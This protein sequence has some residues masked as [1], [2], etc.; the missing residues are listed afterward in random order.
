MSDARSPRAAVH[1]RPARLTLAAALCTPLM[2]AG[3]YVVPVAPAAEPV[4]RPVYPKPYHHPRPYY[5]G[6]GPYGLD[7][8]GGGAAAEARSTRQAGGTGRPAEAA[9]VAL[10]FDAS[11]LAIA[12]GEGLPRREGS[13]R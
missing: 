5:R 7:S 4:Y 13:P 12:E 11:A 10:A 6:Y 9:D 2:M 8:P 1:A 3:C